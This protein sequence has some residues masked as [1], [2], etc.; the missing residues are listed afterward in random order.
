MG[1]Q[2]VQNPWHQ[3]SNIN[4]CGMLVGQTETTHQGSKLRY[5]HTKSKCIIHRP[6]A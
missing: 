2:T 1:V 4:D 5:L 3:N 6:K